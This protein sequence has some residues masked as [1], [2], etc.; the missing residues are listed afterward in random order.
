MNVKYI[1]GY[2]NTVADYLS[3]ALIKADKNQ[4]PILQVHQITNKL[5]C[6]AD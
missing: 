1:P 2:I 6:T 5:R 3:R 4:L